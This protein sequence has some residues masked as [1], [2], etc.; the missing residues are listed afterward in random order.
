MCDKPTRERK[1][2]TYFEVPTERQQ[3]FATSGAV[4]QAARAA[5]RGWGEQRLED[6]AAVQ[7]ARA[8]VAAGDAGRRQRSLVGAAS[9]GGRRKRRHVAAGTEAA[10]QAGSPRRVALV[11]PHAASISLLSQR[12]AHPTHRPGRARPRGPSW[13]RPAA[14]GFRNGC[15]DLW[16]ACGLP[17][18]AV[19]PAAGA[20]SV[21]VRT[22]CSGPA[23]AS[24]SLFGPWS[25]RQL[26]GVFGGAGGAARSIGREQKRSWWSRFEWSTGFE[27]LTVFPMPPAPFRCQLN[28]QR[29]S[30]HREGP[31]RALVC[32]QRT[33]SARAMP[34]P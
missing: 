27:F 19:L 30:R 20:L 16:A 9:A 12:P 1:R 15:P 14:V 5:G 23:A 11:E 24:A 7:P 33:P 13:R 25:V 29:Q 32:I 31:D 34:P 10:G 22:V 21:T 28:R 26:L 4:Q 3:G 8:P 2:P 6:A 18:T 17:A